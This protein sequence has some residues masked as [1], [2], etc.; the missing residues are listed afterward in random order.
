MPECKF[1]GESP[2]DLRCVNCD[3]YICD[4]HARVPLFSSRKKI[5]CSGCTKRKN[6]F[7]LPFAL[8]LIIIPIIACLVL[9]WTIS[10]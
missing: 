3:A 1:C 8:S 4:A 2:V 9:L 7:R 5:Y 6:M 10:H